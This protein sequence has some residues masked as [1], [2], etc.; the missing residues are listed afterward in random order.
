[1]KNNSQISILFTWQILLTN[2][3]EVSVINKWEQLYIYIYCSLKNTEHDPFYFD[4][5]TMYSS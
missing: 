1:M 3:A 4:N 2:F 5:K